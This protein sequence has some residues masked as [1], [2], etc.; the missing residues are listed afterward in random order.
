MKKLIS[1]LMVVCLLATLIP[2]GILCTSAASS[3]A[4]YRGLSDKLPL[5]TYAMPLSGASKVYAYADASLGTKQSGYY[6]CS[7]SDQI[8]ITEISG[9]GAAVKATYPSSSAPGGYRSKWFRADDV[10][11]LTSVGVSSY[12][13]S[14]GSKTYRMK[15]AS[16]V[17]S[18]GSIAKN[19]SCVKL[20]TH[21][22][23]GTNYYPTVYNI[24]GTTVNRVGGV[25]N[26]LALATNAGAVAMAAPS[27]SSGGLTSPVPSGVCFNKQS[28]DCGSNWYGYHDININVSTST[29]VYAIADGTVTYEQ[30]YITSGGKQY[31]VSY[32][33]I[34]QFTSK[35]KVYKAKYC[36]LSSFSGATQKIPSSQ[37]MQWS[38]STC[39]SK[40]YSV[41]THNLGTR[42]VKKGEI[43]GYIG[44]TGN[45]T[46]VHLHFELFKN[47]SR[48]NPVAIFPAL[49]K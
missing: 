35:D 26:K 25:R 36:H 24:S 32:G 11:G 3:S 10:L 16:G 40:G 38:A 12:K 19:D 30:K 4:V 21:K 2:A 31:L 20:G 9:N 6:I 41:K 43:L 44:T 48:Q 27:T 5:V 45:S 34:V 28:N 39:K 42:T 7:F 37:T 49:K 13:A 29:P 33:N 18:Y 23:G 46:G 22:I 17:T 15:S 1:M 14:A 47:G 8:V